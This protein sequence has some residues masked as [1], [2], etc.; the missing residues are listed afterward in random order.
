[1]LGELAG[2]GEGAVERDARVEESREFLG[3]EEDVAP[4]A[5]AERRQFDL[6]ARGLGRDA[7]VNRGETLF[8]EVARDD[9]FVVAG[10]AAGADLTV[11]GH[12]T[13]EEGGHL[14]VDPPFTAGTRRRG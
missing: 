8:A 7:N 13:E 14:N 2:D 11:G 12:G 6:E 4:A 9:L 5:F 3:E 1:M 10:D